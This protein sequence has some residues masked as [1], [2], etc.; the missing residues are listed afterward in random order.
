MGMFD[1]I[2]VEIEIP[3]CGDCSHEEFQTKSFDNVMENYVITKNGKLYCEKWEYDWVDDT[4]RLLNGY[5]EKIPGSYRREYLTDY[6]GDV[7]FYKRVKDTLWRDYYARFTEGK[8]TKMWYI[9]T[10]Y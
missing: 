5:V 4:S 3:G 7:I 8:L 9:D 1:T 6:H 2:R 10:Q